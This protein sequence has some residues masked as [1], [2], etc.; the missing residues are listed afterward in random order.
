MPRTLLAAITL[1][2]ALLAQSPA[3][4]Q[5][6]RIFAAYQH[7]DTPGC[8]AGVE[9]TGREIWTAAYGMADLEHAAAN[10]PATVFEAGGR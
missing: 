9:T 6:A 7:P 3:P 1:S 4:D 5:L 10:T 8:A 2:G